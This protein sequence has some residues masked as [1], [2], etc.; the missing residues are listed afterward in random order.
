MTRGEYA[1]RARELETE[2]AGL[3]DFAERRDASVAM[4]AKLGVEGGLSLSKQA[5]ATLQ[6]VIAILNGSAPWRS[7]EP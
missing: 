7:E 2:L 4:L 5:K 1:K 6:E 3:R